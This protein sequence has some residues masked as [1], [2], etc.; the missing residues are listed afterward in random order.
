MNCDAISTK[1]LNIPG[2]LQKIRHVASPAVPDQ[3]YL[4]DIYTQ[5]YRHIDLIMV[6]PITKQ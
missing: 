2:H 4:I 6:N 1:G 3:R 5:S